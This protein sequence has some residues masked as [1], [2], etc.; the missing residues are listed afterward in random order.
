M[1]PAFIS[2]D[3]YNME[4]QHKPGKAYYIT[5]SKKWLTSLHE[6]RGENIRLKDQLSEAI[7]RDVSPDFI[8]TVER[9][10]QLFLEKDQIID[11]LR[12]DIKVLLYS[13]EPITDSEERQYIVIEKDIE[14]LTD[15]FHKMKTSFGDFLGMSKTG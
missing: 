2:E 5:E 3:W 12:H 7:S 11:L 10:Q 13:K 9:F 6:L 14:Q 1:N 8:D 15:D 4:K